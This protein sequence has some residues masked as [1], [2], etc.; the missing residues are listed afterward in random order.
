MRNIFCTV[1]CDVR[2]RFLT[3]LLA[4][5]VKLK[6]LPKTQNVSSYIF[7]LPILCRVRL[8]SQLIPLKV[9][10]NYCLH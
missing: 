9:L 1:S 7:T 5:S 8:K 10:I 3:L 6:E 2:L 4:Y